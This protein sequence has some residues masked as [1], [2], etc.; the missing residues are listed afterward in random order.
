M[1]LKGWLSARALPSL[2]ILSLICVWEIVSR[3]GIFVYIMPP[4]SL[5]I[6]R[7]IQ[8][9]LSGALTEH[10]VASL[11]RSFMGYAL[12]AALGISLGIILGWSSRVYRIFEP[13]IELLRP[14]PSIAMIPL[15][16][17][18]L[19]I[20]EAPKIFIISFACF[21]PILMNTIYGVR[22]VD[23][24]LIKAARSMNAKKGDLLSKVAVPA[25][26]PYIFG[27]LRI[28]LATSFVLLIASEMVAAQ[29]G[30]GY[31]ILLYEETFRIK[32]MYGVIILLVLLAYL[33][34]RILLMIE[35]HL[36]A[37]HKAIT[38]AKR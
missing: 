29:N 36:I 8:M 2:I 32:E 3:S 26:S 16:I 19:G 6:L 11:T 1:R 17:L 33:S 27:G 18:W 20:G 37:W 14:I 30:L 23:D 25:A 24:Y 28:S 4:F 35:N 12:A 38:I 9:L 5:I 31:L 13:L 34:N 10:I 7:L 15:A 21:W 22:G